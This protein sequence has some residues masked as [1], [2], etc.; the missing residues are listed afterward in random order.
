MGKVWVRTKTIA[1]TDVEIPHNRN[2]A[3]AVYGFLELGAEVKPYHDL[4]DIINKVTEQD[5]VLDYMDACESVLQRFG[6]KPDMP[7]YPD[8][9]R[10]FFG[11]RIWTD[12]IQHIAQNEGLWS[13]GYFVKPIRRK[14]FA[15]RIVR[16]L[17]DLIG[18][19]GRSGLTEVYVSE[20]IDILAEWRCFIRY[21]RILDVRPYGSRA[22]AGYDGYL[23]HYDPLVLQEMLTA[24]QTWENRPAAWAMDICLTRDGK[25]LLVECNDAYAL[26]S[27]GLPEVL[28][29]RMISARWSQLLN[30]ED[31]CRF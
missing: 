4:E 23:Y 12:T 16:G 11:R 19:A 9:L 30:R 26:G 22:S 1:G 8:V 3:N 25:T 28:Y 31:A 21:D 17:G 14:A 29:A 20:Q 10:A 13:A 7:T 18:C 2:L 24:F 6:V 15:G 5:I 27:Y